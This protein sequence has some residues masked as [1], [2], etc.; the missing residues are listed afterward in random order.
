MELAKNGYIIIITQLSYGHEQS[1]FNFVKMEGVCFF[2]ESSSM[3]GT[4]A[5]RRG[6][7]MFTFAASTMGPYA[8]VMAVQCCAASVSK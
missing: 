1:S 7:M 8:S 5:L 6:E 3:R 2:S 4:D